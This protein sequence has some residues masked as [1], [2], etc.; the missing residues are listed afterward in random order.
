LIGLAADSIRSRCLLFA[1]PPTAIAGNSTIE[2]FLF[3]EYFELN[4]V[5]KIDLRIGTPRADIGAGPANPLPSTLAR[6]P[7]RL[8]KTPGATGVLNTLTKIS[9]EPANTNFRQVNPRQDVTENSQ[10]Y[11]FK[12]I[13]RF[14]KGERGVNQDAVRR[15]TAWG[16]KTADLAN[17]L[18]AVK[19][20]EDAHIEPGL[21]IYND[22]MSACLKG[23]QVYDALEVFSRMRKAGVLPDVSA[24]NVLIEACSDS[25]MFKKA[26]DFVEVMRQAGMEPDP[27]IHDTLL[28][29]SDRSRAAD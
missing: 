26:F 28:A 4:H 17:S 25:G 12:I 23:E 19:A 9:R 8:L 13:E 24:F 6:A 27:L 1:S 22:L 16:M 2:S 20:M 11:N 7:N 10:P 3:E 14:K 18:L 15:V 5:A 29:A 21:G